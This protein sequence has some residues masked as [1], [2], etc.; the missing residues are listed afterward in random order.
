H[1]SHGNR[2]LLYQRLGAERDVP[3][4]DERLV[5]LDVDIEISGNALRHLGH[6][7]GAAKVV[8]PGQHRLAT[9]PLDSVEN[10]FVRGCDHDPVRHSAGRRP[11]PNP[12]DHRLPTEVDQRLAR[13][14]RAGHSSRDHDQATHNRMVL[15]KSKRPDHWRWPGSSWF[16]TKETGSLETVSKESG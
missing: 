1:R 4:V 2:G 9:K 11:L 6:P 13:E 12:L 3:R 15:R 5:S 16:F 7:V 10:L 8:S 14:P